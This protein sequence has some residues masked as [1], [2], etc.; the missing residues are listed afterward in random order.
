[1]VPAFCQQHWRLPSSPN[2]L[3]S[4]C[5]MM[6]FVHL[7]HLNRSLKKVPCGFKLLLK[8]KLIMSTIFLSVVF[9]SLT[10]FMEGTYVLMY[11]ISY[12][13]DNHAIYI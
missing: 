5:A 11:Q 13:V 7:G 9:K 4:T 3:S 12:Y 10:T 1:M 6:S 8:K 2:R